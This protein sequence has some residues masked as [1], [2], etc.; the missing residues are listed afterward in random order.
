MT[1]VPDSFSLIRGIYQS[2]MSDGG[3]VS[4]LKEEIF[5]EGS[6]REKD[7]LLKQL[8]SSK[9]K[10]KRHTPSTSAYSSRARDSLITG[11]RAYGHSA[12]LSSL[13]ALFCRRVTWNPGHT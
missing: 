3:R 7:E 11:I 1:L 4:K 12:T 8:L 2:L 5:D 9:K 6:Q 10:K 13:V